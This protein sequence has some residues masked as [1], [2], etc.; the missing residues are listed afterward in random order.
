MEKKINTTIGRLEELEEEEW[1]GENFLFETDE[2]HQVWL[3]KKHLV[4]QELGL[5]IHSGVWYEKYEDDEDDSFEPDFD[6]IC[7]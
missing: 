2:E 1:D 4:I 6:F 7:F 3:D 5:Q